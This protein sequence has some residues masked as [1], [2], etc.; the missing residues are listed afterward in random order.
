M[1]ELASLNDQEFSW[2]RVST[3]EGKAAGGEDWAGVVDCHYGGL[4]FFGEED[5]DGG[6]AGGMEGAVAEVDEGAAHGAFAGPGEGAVHGGEAL[7]AVDGEVDLLARAG[8]ERVGSGEGGEVA[9]GEGNGRASVSVAQGLEEIEDGA[10]GFAAGFGV[11]EEADAVRAAKVLDVR[12]RGEEGFDE[13]ELAE[14][15]GGKER[16]NGALG[17]KVLG[18]G[19]VAHVRSGTESSFPI[20]EAPVPGG[21]GERGAGVNEFADA[22]EVEVGDGDHFADEFGG[23]GGEGVADGRGEVVVVLR[24]EGEKPG[25]ESHCGNDGGDKLQ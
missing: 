12:L 10:G 25:G 13:I 2:P 23:L 8:A 5:A 22:V 17:E 9:V 20:A 24:F 3:S 1:Q 14:N 7:T 6:R 18:N 15:G 11:G 21:T 16:R 19:A 4:L